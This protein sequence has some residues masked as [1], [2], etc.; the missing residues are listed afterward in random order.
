[1]PTNSNFGHFIGIFKEVQ[2]NSP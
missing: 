1:M 2:E